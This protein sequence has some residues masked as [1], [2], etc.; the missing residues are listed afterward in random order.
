MRLKDQLLQTKSFSHDGQ[1]FHQQGLAHSSDFE[2][3]YTKLRQKE[4]R[5]YDDEVVR[6]LPF[7]PQGVRSKEW[8][9]RSYTAKLLLEHLKRE[10]ANHVIMDLGCGNGWLSHFLARYL[11]AE[12]CGVDVNILELEQAGRVFGQQTKLSF[13]CADIM[14]VELPLQYFD[15]IIL[16]ASIQYFS[17]PH[18][19]VDRLYSLLYN[20]GEVHIVDSPLY[21]SYEAANAAK[22]RSARYFD[23]VGVPEMKQYYH[24][25]SFNDFGSHGF[26]VRFDPGS[27]AS[28][29]RAKLLH[30]PYPIFPWIIF[31]K[32]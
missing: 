9:A 23:S 25:H 29:L 24:H 32:T 12:V 5:F 2:N 8:E 18:L 10:S 20:G 6:T 27:F 4:N 31:I 7:P 3:S 28:L 1:V 22:V 19:L 11:D 14:S 13:L 17:K 16:A 30:K 15:T 26:T 21:K